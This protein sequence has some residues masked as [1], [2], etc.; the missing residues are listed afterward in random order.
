MRLLTVGEG[1]VV[2]VVLFVVLYLYDYESNI[3]HLPCI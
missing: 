1:G 3:V 2:N